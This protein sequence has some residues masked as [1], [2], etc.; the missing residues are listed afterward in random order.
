MTGLRVETDF[1]QV[2]NPCA[3]WLAVLTRILRNNL[4]YFSEL[5]F[6]C[7]MI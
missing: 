6:F 3:K 1:Y 7:D 4:K 5:I 2:F